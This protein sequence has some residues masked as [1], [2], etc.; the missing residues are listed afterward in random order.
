MAS[1]TQVSLK[2]SKGGI[3]NSRNLCFVISSLF[4]EI[5]SPIVQ[6]TYTNAH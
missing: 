2:A 3:F 4:L 1:M 6:S 5:K